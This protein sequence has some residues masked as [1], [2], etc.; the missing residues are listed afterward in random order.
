MK[1]F[2]IPALFLSDI[3]WWPF[4]GKPNI[5]EVHVLRLHACLIEPLGNTV[6]VGR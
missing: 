3:I 6:R 5:F 2:A 1:N 4:P